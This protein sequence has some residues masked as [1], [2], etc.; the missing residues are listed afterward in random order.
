MIGMQMSAHDVVDLLGCYA[1]GGK[2]V[3]PVV[4]TLMEAWKIGAVL[5]VAAAAIDQDHVPAGPDQIGAHGSSKFPC[6]RIVVD[7]VHPA[8]MRG[9]RVLGAF[10]QQLLRNKA[11]LYA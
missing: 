2:P 4:V 8:H 3:E 6:A 9:E 5:V 10:R 7:R 11:R 1:C